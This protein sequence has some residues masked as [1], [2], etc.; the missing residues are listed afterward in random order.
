MEYSLLWK[1]HLSF[2][3][4]RSQHNA[5]PKSTRRNV[6]L[7]KFTFGT[8]WLPDL[9]CHQYGISAAKT[10]TFLCEERARRNGCFHWLPERV[11][12]PKHH[13]SVMWNQNPRLSRINLQQCEKEGSFCAFLQLTNYSFCRLNNVVIWQIGVLC[14]YLWGLLIY[15]CF[16][17]CY[18][19]GW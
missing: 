12:N 16:T 5:L 6:R 14:K 15:P 10:Q 13:E 19:I 17:D 7:N 4:D 9:S 18:K 3:G 1:K 11:R 2:A 8:P